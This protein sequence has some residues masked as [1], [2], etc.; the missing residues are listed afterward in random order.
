VNFTATASG[1]FQI[2]VKN[3]RFDGFNEFFAVAW[4]LT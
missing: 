1:N 2:K 4:S 3:Y